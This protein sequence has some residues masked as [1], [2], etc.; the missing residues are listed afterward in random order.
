MSGNS[1]RTPTLPNISLWTMVMWY[2]SKMGCC[3]S[4]LSPTVALLSWNTCHIFLSSFVDSV[5]GLIRLVFAWSHLLNL[6]DRNFK[7]KTE[8]PKSSSYSGIWVLLPKIVFGKSPIVSTWRDNWTVATVDINS[9]FKTRNSLLGSDFE[10]NK[11][12]CIAFLRG[13]HWTH[14]CKQNSIQSPCR[15]L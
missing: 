5:V 1:S 14:R 12:T 9:G 8:F 6:L 7:F 10:T 4:G 11:A 15:D 2:S 13:S 3:V